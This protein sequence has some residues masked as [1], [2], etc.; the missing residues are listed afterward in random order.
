MVF[1]I[2]VL[3]I[4]MLLLPISTSNQEQKGIDPNNP[5]VFI[6]VLFFRDIFLIYQNVLFLYFNFGFRV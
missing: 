4:G 1:C 2:L 5:A 6:S 3:L